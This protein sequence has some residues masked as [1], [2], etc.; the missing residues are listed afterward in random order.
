M[1]K[2][3]WLSTIVLT[4]VITGCDHGD[5]TNLCET[6]HLGNIKFSNP[7]NGFNPDSVTVYL[8][9]SNLGIVPLH[10]ELI[11]TYL[12]VGKHEY[13]F[14]HNY[15]TIYQDSIDV[16]ECTTTNYPID[17]VPVSDKRLKKNIQPLNNVLASLL[18]LNTYTF[19]YNRS[20]F[21]NYGLPKGYHFGFM[22]Q[23]LQKDFPN[24]VVPFRDGY[25]AVNYTEM[26]PVLTK[27]IQ[28][29]QKE[30]DALKKEMADLKKAV[31]QQ[32]TA[33]N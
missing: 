8:G 6:N 15:D 19:E 2:I 4:I 24:V 17:W 7:D 13:T 28:E 30:I 11:I 33:M 27:A 16:L 12:P 1:K 10:G 29:Q 21:P 26:I 3:L 20:Q 23:E 9:S 5:S 14:K 25:F 18:N 22:A 31:S 32:N